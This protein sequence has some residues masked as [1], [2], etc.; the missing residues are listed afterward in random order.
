M[1]DFAERDVESNIYGLTE[2]SAAVGLCTVWV[3]TPWRNCW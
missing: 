3:L 1:S 2:F